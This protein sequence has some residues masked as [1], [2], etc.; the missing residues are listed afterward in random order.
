MDTSSPNP[1]YSLRSHLWVICP[2]LAIQTEQNRIYWDYKRKG[3]T[4][5]SRL[6]GNV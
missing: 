4:L 2:N 6:T 1:K 5:W 3:A